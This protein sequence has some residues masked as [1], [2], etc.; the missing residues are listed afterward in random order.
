MHTEL[1]LGKDSKS[2]IEEGLVHK[3]LASTLREMG[4]PVLVKLSDDYNSR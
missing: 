3:I 1:G 4:S 2:G